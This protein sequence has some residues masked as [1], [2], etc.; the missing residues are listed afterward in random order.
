MAAVDPVTVLFDHLRS[1]GL[2]SPQQLQELGM[3]II[4]QR[5]DVQRLAAELERRGWLTIFQ[6]RE[7]TQ[8]RGKQLQ[9]GPYLLLDL[10]GEGGMGRVYKARHQRLGR[11]CAIKVIR[12]ERLKHPAVE[13]R[14]R[15]EIEALGRM[16]HPN[17]VEVFNADQAGD[18][19]YYE[20]EWID[21]TDLTKLVKQ[22]G[23]L[24]IAQAC[25]YIRQ[26]ALGL[27]HAHE[28]GLVH[29]DIKPSNILVSWDGRQVKL[30]DMGLARIL[31]DNAAGREAAKRIT[32]E[33]LVLGTPDFLA[34]EQARNPMVVDIRADIYSL[35]GTLYYVLTGRVPYE[36]ANP[37]E[38]MLRH[39]T[40]PPP[41][42]L[43]YRPDAP[44]QLEQLIHWCMAKQPE[45]RPQTP[46]QLAVALQPFC[47][48]GGMVGAGTAAALPAGNWPNAPP[49]E[50][51]SSQI[52]RLPEEVA[53]VAV[54]RRRSAWPW[55]LLGFALLLLV[56]FLVV[57]PRLNRLWVI[58]DDRPAPDSFT[59]TVGLRLVRLSPGE[60]LMGSSETEKGRRPEEGPR[61]RVRL[62]R[63]FLMSVTEVTNGQFQQVMGHI[64]S[65]SSKA[66]SRS[67]QLPVESVTWWEAVEF[68]R[69][70]TEKEQK[71][72]WA[73]SGWGYR[74]PTEAEW[75]YAARAGSDTPFAFG[76]K[77]LF[78]RQAVYKPEEEDP[79]GV[80]GDLHRLPALPEEVG[81]RQESSFGLQD[82]HGNVAEW[83][84]DWYQTTYPAGAEV[85]LDP[86]GPAD[87][88]RRVVRGGSY[89]LPATACR[90]AAR[91]S[92]RPDSRRPDVGFRVVYAPLLEHK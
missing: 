78:G 20:M 13:E 17:V 3:W 36:G 1:C 58:N 44:R 88:D 90:S 10:L 62:S 23:P 89:A 74:L 60:F 92:L 64:P 37:T 28:L 40:D 2:L 46:I 16:H 18:V 38:K 7:I 51:R 39:C 6:V 57:A 22:R 83:C 65:Q 9:L 56:S 42:L 32:R 19:I 11:L 71:E 45:Q 66:A 12:R 21:G 68:C 35:G 31:D 24:P 87:G 14:F 27:Q 72:P 33:G 63:A 50:P 30:V 75:E 79:Y 4:A 15:K 59:N 85:R 43:P 52:F 82:M 91:F 70:L 73:R 76:D 81:R 34:P 26:A 55:G 25:D 8:G 49:Q 48:G 80:G 47:P 41:P 29:R 61:H 67:L 69:K 77:L 86:T 5:P 84:W 53:V 54:R